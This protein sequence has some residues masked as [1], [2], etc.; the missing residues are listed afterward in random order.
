MHSIQNTI[1]RIS[2]RSKN[3]PGIRISCIILMTGHSDWLV[4]AGPS[5]RTERKQNKTLQ[6]IAPATAVIMSRIALSSLPSLLFLS[7]LLSLS[8]TFLF[9]VSVP[10]SSAAGLKNKRNSIGLLHSN[11]KYPFPMLRKILSER[12]PCQSS[13]AFPI[14]I[15]FSIP[16][17]DKITAIK[18]VVIIHGKM[19]SKNLAL[20]C[21]VV[22]MLYQSKIAAGKIIN[23]K[24]LSGM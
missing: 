16:I 17:N 23:K 9:F 21:N 14:C 7:S 13:P 18:Y 10:L 6:R 11:I 24:L 8:S 3:P 12:I 5:V 2:N 4:R 22:Y 19:I 15:A 1:G 20:F